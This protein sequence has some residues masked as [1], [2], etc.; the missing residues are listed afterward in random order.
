MIID[1]LSN[2]ERYNQVHPLF[3]QAFEYLKSQD[4]ANMEIGK[5]DI[6][7]GLKA[8]VSD[9]KGMTAEESAAKFECHDH[10]IDIQLCIRGTEKIGWKPRADCENLK[11]EY[12]P[13]KDVSFYS[14]APDMH[15]TLTNNQF[16]IFFPEDVHAP[17]ISD[18]EV[19]KLVVKIKM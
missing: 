11:G 13:E 18:G 10:H 3:A 12:N 16:A 7:D 19:K 9:K 6:A 14:D 5:Y 8:I 17:M 1:S 15:F 2:T 4:L